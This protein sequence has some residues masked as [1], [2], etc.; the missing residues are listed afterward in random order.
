MDYLIRSR[1]ETLH[2]DI[3]APGP[4]RTRLLESLEDCCH[5]RCDC[6][7]DEY[8]KLA[9]VEIEERGESLAVDL[10]ARAGEVL[11]PVEISR[12]IDWTI[13]NLA[14]G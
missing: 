14:A 12:C 8:R 2:V 7:T 6:P 13:S 4:H 5:G 9:R 11:D 1:G 3:P 10:T